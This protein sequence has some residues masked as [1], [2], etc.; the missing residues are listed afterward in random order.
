VGALTNP[1]LMAAWEG[2]GTIAVSSRG[3]D[4]G[5]GRRWEEPHREARGR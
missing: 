1:S 3:R 5:G 2:L 4:R